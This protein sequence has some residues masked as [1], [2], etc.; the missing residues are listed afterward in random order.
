ME[1][2]TIEFQEQGRS[3]RFLR[4]TWLKVGPERTHMH[5]IVQSEAIGAFRGTQSDELFVGNLMGSLW[6]PSR[7]FPWRDFSVRS[8][9]RV[10]SGVSYRGQ[11]AIPS[12]KC[13][14]RLLSRA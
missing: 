14:A 3:N 5:A 12:S 2:C 4:S 9:P 7:G 13:V 10:Q 6:L 1:C 8:A 11:S